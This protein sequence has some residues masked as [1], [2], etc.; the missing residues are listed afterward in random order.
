MN[1]IIAKFSAMPF[2][3][4]P[5]WRDS[6]VGVATDYGMDDRGVGVPVSS[7]R[8][9]DRLWTPPNLLSNGYLGFFSRG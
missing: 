6:V 7:P 8:R 2:S 5:R 9:P 4:C 1:F 3:Y